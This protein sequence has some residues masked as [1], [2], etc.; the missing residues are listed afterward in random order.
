M[1]A[2]LQAGYLRASGTSPNDAGRRIG[3]GHAAQNKR[4][5]IL[6]QVDFRWAN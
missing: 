3:I 2:Y 1:L 4:I 6:F 5:L